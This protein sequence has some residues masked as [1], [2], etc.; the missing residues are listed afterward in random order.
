MTEQSWQSV[1]MN[2]KVALVTGANTGIGFETALALAKRG[3]KV[4][5]HGRSESKVTAAVAAIRASAA[6]GEVLPVIADLAKLSE[7][8]A[9]AKTVGELTTRLDVLVN[10]AGLI[11]DKRI[12]TEDGFETTFAVNHLAPF[13]LTHALLDL[14]KASAPARVV[15]VSSD[16]HRATQG[17]DFDDLQH[18]KRYEGKLVYQRSKLANIYFAR[19]LARRLAGTGVTSNSLHPGVVRTRFGQDG[20][21]GGLLAFFFKMARPFFISPEAGA[22]TS[23]HLAMAPEVATVSGE[24]FAKSKVVQPSAVARDDAAAERLWT[25]SEEAVAQ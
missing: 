14:L 19:V 16:W 18:E 21:M 3:A 22:Q 12:V 4:F 1:D 23:L 9:L 7:V 24:Y 8:R 20:D 17:L 6:T 15:T 2:G 13:V 11:L 5:V 10:N 25:W